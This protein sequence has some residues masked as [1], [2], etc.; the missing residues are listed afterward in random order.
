MQEIQKYWATF[1]SQYKRANN[2]IILYPILLKKC[3]EYQYS[4]IRIYY[5]YD[6]ASRGVI[7]SSPSSAASMRENVCVWRERGAKEI[8]NIRSGGT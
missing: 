3:N 7:V 1:Q 2:I 8:K 6:V 5:Y 4:I